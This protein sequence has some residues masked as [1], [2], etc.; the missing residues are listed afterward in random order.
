MSGVK[1]DDKNEILAH[2]SRRLLISPL[3]YPLIRVQTFMQSHLTFPIGEKLPTL[4]ESFEL[5]KNQGGLYKGF[6]FQFAYNTGVLAC[7]AI[8]PIIGIA[9]VGLLYPL[10][11]AQVYAASHGTSHINAWEN[12]K[13][14]LFNKSN[15]RGVGLNYL[16]FL[17]PSGFFFNNIKRN[18]ILRTDG[19]N[20]LTYKDVYRGLSSSGMLMRGA[21][22]GLILFV[23]R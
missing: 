8:N 12:L 15:Y 21:V 11:M 18:Y 16:S 22:P 2:F 5:A 6:S 3:L 4:K 10:E 7:W 14:N 17:D 19:G 1:L 23:F 20:A 9:S 13:K